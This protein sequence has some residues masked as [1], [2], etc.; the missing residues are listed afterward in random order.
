MILLFLFAAYLESLLM[1]I[2]LFLCEQNL[3]LFMKDI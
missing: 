1:L 2:C 3:S